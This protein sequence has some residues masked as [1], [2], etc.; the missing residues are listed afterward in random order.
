M[1][2]MTLYPPNSNQLFNTGLK[3]KPRVKRSLAIMF[4]EKSTHYWGY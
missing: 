3:V 2:G 1:E 4:V